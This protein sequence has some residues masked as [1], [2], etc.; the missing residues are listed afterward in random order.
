MFGIPQPAETKLTLN[1]WRFLG[2]AAPMCGGALPD[3]STPP[4]SSAA[5]PPGGTAAGKRSVALTVG[6]SPTAHRGGEAA[7]DLKPWGHIETGPNQHMDGWTAL[8]F[9]RGRYGA[10]DWDRMLRQRC[11]INAI[12]DQANPI[13]FLTRYEKLAAA[14]KQ[15]VTTDMPANVLPNLVDLSLKV[16]D[17]GNLTNIAFTNDVIHVANPEH[18]CTGVGHATLDGA[19]VDPHAI[20]IKDDDQTHTVEIVLGKEAVASASKA[21]DTRSRAV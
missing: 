15:I 18:R 4:D 11:V 5:S 3:R 2:F 12:V 6:P 16:K 9:A 1:P 7:A 17:A 14:S 20:P 13:N 8:W 19:P 21:A 10:S